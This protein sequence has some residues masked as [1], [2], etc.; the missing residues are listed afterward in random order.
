M[1]HLITKV[2]FILPTISNGCLFWSES[3]TSM[4]WNSELNVFKNIWSVEEISNKVPNGYLGQTWT[5]PLNFVNN[6]Y[7]QYYKEL[8]L[9]P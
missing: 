6:H 8:I 4:S 1:L 9:L 5:R 7:L 2:R 3:H